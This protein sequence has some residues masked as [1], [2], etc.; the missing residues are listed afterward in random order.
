MEEMQHLGS[1]AVPSEEIRT[2]KFSDKTSILTGV[3]DKVP[4]IGLH[5]PDEETWIV[6]LSVFHQMVEAYVEVYTPDEGESYQ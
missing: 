3:V 5:T 4:V 2:P 6:P 1:L